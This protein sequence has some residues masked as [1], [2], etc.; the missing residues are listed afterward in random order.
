MQV[1]KLFTLK[2]EKKKHNWSQM[3]ANYDSH[4]L[5]TTT[6]RENAQIIL[7]TLSLRSLHCLADIVILSD[8]EVDIKPNALAVLLLLR[9]LLYNDWGLGPRD[10]WLVSV[11]LTFRTFGEIFDVDDCNSRDTGGGSDEPSAVTPTVTRGRPIKNYNF[12]VVI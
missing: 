1:N 8:G 7:H 6:L 5:M 3:T 11:T 9:S 10:C 2:T 12:T 4:R